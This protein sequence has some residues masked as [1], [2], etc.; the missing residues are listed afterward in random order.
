MIWVT[1]K[2]LS[3]DSQKTK[4]ISI[5]HCLDTTNDIILS[6]LWKISRTSKRSYR[7]LRLI[8]FHCTEDRTERY[9]Q[10]C[11]LEKLRFCKFN[12]NSAESGHE[13][14]GLSR[15]SLWW[16]LAQF[17]WIC[18]IL[19]LITPY[20]AVWTWTLSNKRKLKQYL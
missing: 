17:N 13:P 9:S 4:E 1:G 2:V 3:G 5:S 14:P 6:T 10:E 11:W 7:Q 15:S 20:N 18:H 16:F 8:S 19:Y 12:T